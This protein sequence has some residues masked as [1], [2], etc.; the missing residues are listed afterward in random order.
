MIE[1]F[2]RLVPVIR[3]RSNGVVGPCRTV[4]V[5]SIGL[6]LPCLLEWVSIT[7][8]QQCTK[9]D[10]PLL[11]APNSTVEK[12]VVERGGNSGKQGDPLMCLSSLRNG[13][14][15]GGMLLCMLEGSFALP[16]F[17]G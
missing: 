4:K 11:K 12:K 1:L 3:F 7:L 5:F 17:A 10:Y 13:S 8:G 16:W 2:T 6:R 9:W 14:S 15:G